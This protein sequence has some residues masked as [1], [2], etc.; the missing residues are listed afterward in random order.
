MKRIVFGI[1]LGILLTACATKY[2]LIQL[3]D[4]ELAIDKSG[5]LAFSYC[6]KYSMFGKCKKLDKIYYD[7]S[8]EI[9]RIKLNDFRCVHKS[10]LR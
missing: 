8:D 4:R 2:K 3:S 5:K 6:S 9:D 1:C 7:L 10:L